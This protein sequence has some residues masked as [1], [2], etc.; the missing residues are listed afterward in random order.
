MLLVIPGGRGPK[1]SQTDAVCVLGSDVP[2]ELGR[3]KDPGFG[4]SFKQH[5]LGGAKG[6]QGDRGG[7]HSLGTE[8]GKSAFLCKTRAGEASPCHRLA[9]RRSD[10]PQP[11]L[12][13]RLLISQIR[14]IR[15]LWEERCAHSDILLGVGGKLIC[16]FV[17]QSVKPLQICTVLEP[18]T[19][20]ESSLTT[21]QE[22]EK[23]VHA[24]ETFITL[25]FIIAN[26]RPII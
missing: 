8:K 22:G 2:E 25:L 14:S 18:G 16:L 21:E 11:P 26:H 1:E 23:Q 15:V 10:K 20:P 6:H 3:L 7:I 12:E 4:T 24:K 19:L 17:K 13:L 9:P 5:L